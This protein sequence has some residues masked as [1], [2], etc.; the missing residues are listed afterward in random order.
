[1]TLTRDFDAFHGFAGHTILTLRPGRRPGWNELYESGSNLVAEGVEEPASGWQ[2][3]LINE[4][5]RRCDRTPVEG[6][7]PARKRIDEAVQFHIRKSTIDVS[8]TLS[9][10]AIEIIAA[11]NVF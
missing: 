8:V 5:L 4:I 9:R 11:E 6:S 3:D 7:D 1:M 10:V 2:R